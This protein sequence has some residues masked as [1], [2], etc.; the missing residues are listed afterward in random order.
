MIGPDLDT[1]VHSSHRPSNLS[2]T[3]RSGW[4]LVHMAG[5]VIAD[6]NGDVLFFSSR[7]QAREF[8]ARYLCDA[9]DFE[10]H[11]CR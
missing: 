9:E 4:I 11:G 7:E 3:A 6:G 10:L 5:A 2:Q 1:A 8:L